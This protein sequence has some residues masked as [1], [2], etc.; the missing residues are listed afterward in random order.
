[1][2]N[3]SK[4]VTQWANKNIADIKGEWGKSTIEGDA[5]INFKITKDSPNEITGEFTASGQKMWMNE[6][7]SGSKLDRSNPFLSQYTSSSVFNKERLND[8]GFEYAIRTRPK[9]FYQ[10]L[11]GNKHSGSGIGMPHGLR[12][13]SKSTFGNLAVD[14]HEPKHTIEETLTGNTVLN[15]QF[16]QDLL[17]SFGATVKESIAKVVHEK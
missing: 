7:G 8:T 4:A 6:Y 16:K 13:E 1:M 5:E 9:G 11:D 2:S 10:D 12:L 15:E 14:T 17:S 3:I